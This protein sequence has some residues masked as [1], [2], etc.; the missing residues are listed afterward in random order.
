MIV[1]AGYKNLNG[2]KAKRCKEGQKG[3][4][5]EGT[6]ADKMRQ[7]KARKSARVPLTAKMSL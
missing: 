1:M 6:L 2:I 4:Q 5:K 7:D 3:Q